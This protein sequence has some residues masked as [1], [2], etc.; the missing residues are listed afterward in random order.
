MASGVWASQGSTVVDA[1][2][3][4]GVREFT[5]YRCSAELGGLQTNQLKRIKGLEQENARP[6]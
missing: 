2:R 1:V 6:R 5:D 3:Q 4:I